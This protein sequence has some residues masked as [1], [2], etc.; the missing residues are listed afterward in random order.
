VYVLNA[1]GEPVE[2]GQIGQVFVSGAHIA[3]GYVNGKEMTANFLVN[4]IQKTKG[5]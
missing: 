2:R 3:D 4:A 5:I 1:T